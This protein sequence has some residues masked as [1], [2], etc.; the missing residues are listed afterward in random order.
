V[1]NGTAGAPDNDP[2]KQLS[3]SASYVMSRWRVG[4]SYNT[5]N[6]DLGDRD[7]QG[8]FVG[9]RTGPIS[10]LGEIDRI[11]DE[12]PGP[13]R[14]IQVSLLEGNWRFAKGHNLKVSYEFHDPDDVA[15][16]DERERYS[17][18]WEYTPFQLMQSRVGV[19]A[20]NGVPGSAPT[21]RD[22]FFAE[23]HVYF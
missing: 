21:N 11:T 6:S 23:L 14:D 3:A 19:R 2:G 10:W 7:M 5:N 13:D 22:E 16:E 17:L 4:A 18:V 15:E 12:V 8:V 9:L 1:S 20:Y